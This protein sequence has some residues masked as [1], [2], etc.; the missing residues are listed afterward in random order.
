M[1]ANTSP[2]RHGC[3]MV[4]LCYMLIM[5]ALTIAVYALLNEKVRATFPMMANWVLWVFGAGAVAN[6][7]FAV[8]LFRW[9]RWAFYGYCIPAPII[10]AINLS[11]G[12]PF[13]QALIALLGPIILYLA[14]QIGGPNKT[15]N[16]LK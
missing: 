3:V 15:W 8:F 2:K 12:I 6:I 13:L 7:I 5:N 1:E 14:L 11:I 10:F 16:Y 4:W 9:K